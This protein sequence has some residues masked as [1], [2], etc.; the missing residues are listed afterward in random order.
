MRT[1]AR[2]TGSPAATARSQNPNTNASSDLPAK[3]APASQA[4]SSV[5]CFS[6]IM[7]THDS[8]AH[9]VAHRLARTGEHRH[10]QLLTALARARPVHACR[11]GRHVEPAVVVDGLPRD[12]AVAE[13]GYGKRGEF[14]RSAEAADRDAVR[15]RAQVR[16]HHVALDE[17]RS[18]RIGGEVFVGTMR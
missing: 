18:E 14:L 12:V 7:R 5:S 8:R 17:R 6:S 2:A 11:S 1:F 9:D 15:P 4:V 16:G 10:H 3:P 13:N